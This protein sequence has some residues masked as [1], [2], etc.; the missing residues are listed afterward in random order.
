MTTQSQSS[1][2]TRCPSCGTGNQIPRARLEERPSCGRCGKPVFAGVPM[3]LSES[4]FESAISGGLP[5]L[6][7]FWAPWCG[8]CRTMAPEFERAT[9]QLEPRFRTA[10]LNTE[11]SPG[12]SARYSIRSIPTMIVFQDGREIARHSGAVPASEIVRWAET[13]VSG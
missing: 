9:S 3:D 12:V 1:I 7:D 11:E 10:R 5:V 8:P 13:A 4:S 6:I 2:I